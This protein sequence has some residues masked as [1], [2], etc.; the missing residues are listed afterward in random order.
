MGVCL[1]SRK[2]NYSFDMGYAGFHNLRTNI[3]KAY[4]KEL[5]EIYADT[6]FAL[7]DE[8][9]YVNKTNE[10][11]KDERFH[12]YDE[13]I[14]DFLYASDC[15]GKCGYKTCGKIY[16]LIKNIDYEGE[17]FTYGAL[18]DGKDYE[19]LKSFLKECYQKRRM[20]IWC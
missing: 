16:N 9:A 15:S 6:L 17:I 1:T 4:D 7:R 20:M 13:D 19:H 8:Q 12:D 11:L 2:S 10:I 18:S 5:A 3:C 14:L